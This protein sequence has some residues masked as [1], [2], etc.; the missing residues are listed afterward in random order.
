MRTLEKDDKNLKNEEEMKPLFS[1]A[2][3]SPPTSLAV[4]GQGDVPAQ[5]GSRGRAH[6][7]PQGRKAPQSP[8]ERR[9]PYNPRKVRHTLQTKCHWTAACRET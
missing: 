7:T 4:T 6:F 8:G 3:P 9:G 1:E 5:W 2:L